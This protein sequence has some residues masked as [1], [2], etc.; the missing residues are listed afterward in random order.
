MLDQFNK[1]NIHSSPKEDSF[2]LLYFY[3]KKLSVVMIIYI[4]R[5]PLGEVAFLVIAGITGDGEFTDLEE[6]N[7]ARQEAVYIMILV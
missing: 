1:I 4:L 6:A 3:S 2:S 5:H 7:E